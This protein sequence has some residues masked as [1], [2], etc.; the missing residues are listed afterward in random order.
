MGLL[1]FLFGAGMVPPVYANSENF[2][3]ID[4][5][6]AEEFAQSHVEN[7]L[8]LDVFD[9]GFQT[10]IA[11]LDKSKTYKV[12]CRSGNRSGQAERL[13]KSLGFQDVENLGSLSQ[14]A[15]RLNRP[16]K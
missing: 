9:S 15:K 11:K 14:A 7:A 12:Y 1:A 16:T 6:T 13:M 8:N 3:V 10:E 4:V 2:V 5:R